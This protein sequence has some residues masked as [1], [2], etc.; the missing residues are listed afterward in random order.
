M[1]FD[2]T[3]VAENNRVKYLQDQKTEF[4][5][6]LRQLSE[7]MLISAILLKVFGLFIK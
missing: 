3:F 4:S 1:P 7:G 2:L 6:D 5:P